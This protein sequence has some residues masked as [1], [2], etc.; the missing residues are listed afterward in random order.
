MAKKPTQETETAPIEMSDARRG[1][2]ADLLARPPADG[3]KYTDEEREARKAAKQELLSAEGPK[4]RFRRLSNARLNNALDEI[5]LI[6]NLSGPNYEY[7]EAQ[8]SFIRARLHSDVD[9]ALDR[10]KPRENTG[11]KER[12]EIPE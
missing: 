5:A 3:V 7:T 4:E 1:E 9:K 6:G 10:F 8:I 11:A 2:L 12:V